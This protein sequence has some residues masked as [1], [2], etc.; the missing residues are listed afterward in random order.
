MN[1]ITIEDDSRVTNDCR[2]EETT[3]PQYVLQDAEVATDTEVQID[4]LTSAQDAL[5]H[6]SRPGDQIVVNVGP[7]VQG[8][9]TQGLVDAADAD[10]V[11][12]ATPET[13]NRVKAT[14]QNVT[15]TEEAA[16]EAHSSVF[17]GCTAEDVPQELEDL[18][19]KLGLNDKVVVSSIPAVESSVLAALEP[20]PTLPQKELAPDSRSPECSVSSDTTRDLPTIQVVPGKLHDALNA[21]ESILT[22]AGNF[23]RRGDRVVCVRID[24]LNKTSDTQEM[25]GQSLVVALA[26]LSKWSRFDKRTGGWTAIDPCPR[27][28]K[29]LAE[30]WTNSQL[31]TL[32]GTVHQPHLR[33]DGTICTTPG[34]DPATC[35]LG[36]FDAGEVCVPSHPTREHAAKA[37]ELLDDLLSECAFASPEDRSAALSALLT[38]AVRPSLPLAPMFHVM[39]HQPGSGKSY[40]CQLISAVATA[41]PGT[42]VAFP[43][44]NDA[45]DKLLLAQLMRDPAVIEFDNLTSDLRPY[46]KLCSALTSEHLEGRVLGASRIVKVKTK[47]LIMSSGNN[48]RPVADMVRRCICI[49]LDP[50]V[51]TPAARVFKRPHLLDEVRSTRTKYVAAAL[52]V[53]RAWI[54]AGSP[55]T[56]CP[57]LASFV[58]WSDWCRQPL[59]WLDQPDPAECVFKGLREDPE[60]LLLGR[61][62]CGWHEKHGSASLMARD[63]VESAMH[64]SDKDDFREALVEAAGGHD[65][66]NTR[67]LGKWLARHE[68]K[69]VGPHRLRRAPKTRNVESWMVAESVTSV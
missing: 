66:I 55:T 43:R 59:L 27:I 19:N 37:L 35:L 15:L 7:D 26:G 24:Q 62:L 51:E 39:A 12:T 34:Y 10:V 18:L 20:M 57:S 61:V 38:A 29:L 4:S 30:S 54:M 47:V 3:L 64:L 11:N 31:P 58:A 9:H 23:Y 2:L 60:Q 14:G 5:A 53:V 42:P 40:L 69:V 49:Q 22:Q 28:C 13:Q 36:V 25:N 45:C 16:R 56:T 68:G 32:N 8:N 48:V 65:C 50:G 21:A 52:T 41:T 1:K 63:L 46:D 6:F 67:K 33:P 17:P 44:S